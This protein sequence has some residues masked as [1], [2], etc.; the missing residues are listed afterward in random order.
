MRYFFLLLSSL[1]ILSSCSSN[2]RFVDLSSSTEQT[3]ALSEIKVLFANYASNLREKN[4]VSIGSGMTEDKNGKI[5]SF[6]QQGIL[7]GNFDLNEA[8][9]IFIKNIQEFLEQINSAPLLKEKFF[10][11]KISPSKLNFSLLCI[12]E[13]GDYIADGTHI[14][15]I[16]L[17][18]GTIKYYTYSTKKERPL[19]RLE[20]NNPQTT[21]YYYRNREE[22]NLSL[23]KQELFD[24]A[25]KFVERFY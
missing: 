8:R 18:D 21:S 2:N 23:L 20:I 5:Q 6:Y 10:P 19:Y 1:F 9:V 4:I 12:N 13:K 11:Q 17:I 22:K 7:Y 24:D 14:A 16:S 25:K 3:K 15:K